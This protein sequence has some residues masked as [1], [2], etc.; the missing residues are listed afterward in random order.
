MKVIDKILI[1]RTDRLG[2]VLLALPAV[3]Y[4]SRSLEAPIDFLCQREIAPV[5][6][7]YL[8]N[9]KVK[10]KIL[11][12]TTEFEAYSAALILYGDTSLLL[13]LRRTIPLRMGPLSNVSSFFLINR[14]IRQSRSK[15]VMNEAEYNLEMAKAFAQSLMGTAPPV[16]R[17]H[18]SLPVD[19]KEREMAIESL[20]KLGI[21]YKA[22]FIVLHPGM[23]GS[24][25]NPSSQK[26]RE[27]LS[28]LEAWDR[29]P[30]LISIGPSI[31]DKLLCQAL[32]EEK[33]DVR[34]LS[35]VSLSTL[36]EVF[37]MARFVIAP[38]TGPLHLAHYVGT[39][40]VGL[41]S[42]ILSQS[43]KRW[44]PWGGAGKSIT[45]DPQVSCP[46]KR[47]CLGASCSEYLCMERMDWASEIKIQGK[48]LPC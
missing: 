46:G 31:G 28:A 42:P 29:T 36:K 33:P 23:G 1:V 21:D 7:G 15:A 11:E 40:T 35:G 20:R 34:I 8:E 22:P 9:Q 39:P 10:V 4:L 30:V 19:E 45:I 6:T 41:Y 2:D 17:S 38:S 18:I 13:R 37:R 26:Y 24:A 12:E 14:R 5:V 25:L 44:S 48:T 27:I 3:D 32:F 43:A 47:A 16:S